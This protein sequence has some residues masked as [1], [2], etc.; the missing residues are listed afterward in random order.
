M[1]RSKLK[2][3]K[4]NRVFLH[5]QWRSF[6]EYLPVQLAW[7]PA[8][9]FLVFQSGEVN[10]R[11]IS[12]SH[13]TRWQHKTCKSAFLFSPVCTDWCRVVG[14]KNS[15]SNFCG[16]LLYS[17]SRMNYLDHITD[18]ATSRFFAGLGEG[19]LVDEFS[20]TLICL[21]VSKIRQA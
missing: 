2:T 14:L 3:I 20:E 11:R 15:K 7:E 6:A 10:V 8:N 9:R 19:G 16:V 5:A 12:F 13:P 18:P 21:L 4:Q 1:A 17:Y